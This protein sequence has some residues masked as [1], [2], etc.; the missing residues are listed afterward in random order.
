MDHSQPLFLYFVFSL[1]LTVDVKYNF[2]PMTGFEPRKATALPT[3]AQ[4]LPKL[5]IIN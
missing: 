4:P 3:E 2:L 1:Q 5:S